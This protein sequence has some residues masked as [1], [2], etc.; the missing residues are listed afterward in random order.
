MGKRNS[1]NSNEY[2]NGRA[3]TGQPIGSTGF[4]KNYGT[5]YDDDNDVSS[6]FG[7][8]FPQKNFWI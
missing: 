6:E 7:W 3:V 4:K 2:E 5:A 8:P 1:V